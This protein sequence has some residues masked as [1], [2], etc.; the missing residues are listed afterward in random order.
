MSTLTVSSLH[1]LPASKA[2]KWF[3]DGFSL[4]KRAPVKLFLFLLLPL[5]IEGIFQI[6]PAPYGMLASKWVATFVGSSAVIVIHHLATQ[7][8]FSL[9]SIFKAKNWLSMIPLS[10][11]LASAFFIQL[12]VAKLLLGNDGINLLLFSQPT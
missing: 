7:K 8:V 1:N 6:L 12:F 10:A 3:Q 5:I 4:F 11:I 9:K 2:N